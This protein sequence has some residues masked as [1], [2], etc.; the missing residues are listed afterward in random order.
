[1]ISLIPIDKNNC[2]T[3]MT[4]SVA[5]SQKAFVA[6]NQ[7]SL[8]QAYAYRDH[9]RPFAIFSDDQMVGFVML[10][11]NPDKNTAYLWRFMIDQRYQGRGYGKAAMR[12]V[13]DDLRALGIQAVTLDFREGNTIAEAL[14]RSVGFL[15]T[16]EMSDGKVKMKLDLTEGAV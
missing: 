12:R 16:G 3:C 15:P 14:Y 4:L 7:R 2:E 9:A 13:L 10:M 1:M 11:M 6:T 5:E 8:A